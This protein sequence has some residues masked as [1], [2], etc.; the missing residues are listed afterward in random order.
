MTHSVDPRDFAN[1]E[2]SQDSDALVGYLRGAS[3][4]D[5]MRAMND[6]IHHLLDVRK[7]NSVLDVG[8]GTGDAV[9]EL[10]DVVGSKGRVVGVDTATMVAAASSVGV[11]PNAEFV[12]GDAHALPFADGSFDRYR[13]HRV[14]MHLHDPP[15]A[16]AEAVRVVRAG[17]VVV[18]SEPDWGAYAI[19]AEDREVTRGIIDTLQAA[20]AE[21]WIGRR[22]LHLLGSA[23]L[24]S[25]QI[26]PQFGL[27]PSFR[28]AYDFLL[29]DAT[30]KL[31]RERVFDSDRIDA[32]L[33]DLQTRDSD[34]TFFFGG[35]NVVARGL[36]P[37]S[38]R[39]GSLRARLRSDRGGET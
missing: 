14:Y 24:E 22:L 3:L 16:V 19:D 29:A 28:L 21:P 2:E 23:R 31:T 20:M 27:F 10:A 6:Y 15:T 1:V 13:A 30:A 18:V 17:G 9:R 11:P 7:G 38:S 36:K 35:L 37:R 25:V 4:L 39:L 32:W 5:E 33:A 12:V 34:G 8:C 26:A